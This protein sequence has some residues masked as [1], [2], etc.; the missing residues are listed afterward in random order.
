[1]GGWS[2]NTIANVESEDTLAEYFRRVL[3]VTDFVACIYG[4][5][6]SGKSWAAMSLAEDICPEF[7]KE[8]VV[9]TLHDFYEQMKERGK[10][11]YRI[12]CL[13]DFGSELDPGDFMSD[14]GKKTSHFFQKSRTMQTGYFLTTPNK[15]FF[16]KTIR[17]RLADYHIEVV[18]KNKKTGETCLKVQRIQINVKKGTTYYHNLHL[19]EDGLLN[20]EGE[21][22]K[23]AEHIIHRPSEELI[24]WYIPLREALTQ[25]QLEDSATEVERCGLRKERIEIIAS[26]VAINLDKYTRKRNGKMHL[27]KELVMVDFGIGG[28]KILQVVAWLRTEG[29]LPK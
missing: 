16:S 7:Q 27:N 14:P 24:D 25:K 9:F 13:D 18:W 1:M 23:I 21:G 5:K 2:Y 28:R 4:R 10:Q 15:M 17:D 3:E 8:D 11:K 19:S 26:K 20:H 6:Y 22:K 29:Y 12:M